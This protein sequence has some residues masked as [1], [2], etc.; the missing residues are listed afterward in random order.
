MKNPLLLLHG[1]LGS[2]EQLVPLR[3]ILS[4][5]REVF[6]L[7]F[8]G[9]GNSTNEN[10]F[11]IE[12]F[13]QN[14]IDFLKERK[15]SKVDIFGYSMGGYVTLNLASNY[16]ERV[17]NIITL[18]TKFNWNPEFAEKEIKMLD[19]SQIQ[20]KVPAFANRLEQLHGK[21][22][23][24]RVVEKTAKMMMHL[25]KWPV[26]NMENLQKIVNRTLI[27]LGNLDKM[28]TIE[29]S[30]NVANWLKNGEFKLIENFKHP[31]ETVPLERLALI[32]NTFLAEENK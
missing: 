14:I 7:D 2:S 27:C 23:W 8:Q 11:S 16:P 21:E 15:I 13:T 9:H 30:E 25:G 3:E 19:P 4:F 17:G 31:I 5:E 18:G 24:K 28:S 20:E 26:L 32:I 29:E 6:V 1:A 10:D 12:L 22:D